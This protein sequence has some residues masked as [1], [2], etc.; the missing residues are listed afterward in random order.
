VFETINQW[1][2]EYQQFIY[3]LI[4][5]YCVSKASIL[6][7]FAGMLVAAE[8]LVAGPALGA[9]IAGGFIGDMLRFVLARKYGDALVAKMPDALAMWMRKTL[10]LF[11][12]YGI[13][14]ILLCRYPHGVRSFGV[15]PVGMSSMS[16]IRFLPLSITSVVLWAGLY[17]SLGYSVGD[18][19]ADRT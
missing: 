11:E 6:P 10:R 17:F 5:T 16:F 15:F 13:A 9:M 14:Y 3:I 2:Q 12:H 8:S 7:V 18:V 19:R 4:F 1:V